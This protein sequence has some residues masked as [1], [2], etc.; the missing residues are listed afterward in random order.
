MT[1]ASVVGGQFEGACLRRFAA[2]IRSFKLTHYEKISLPM[3][4]VA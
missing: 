1:I 2:P 3:P 4:N